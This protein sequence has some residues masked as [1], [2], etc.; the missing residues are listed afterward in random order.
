MAELVEL[1]QL[2]RAWP[3]AARKELLDFVAYLQHK[4]SAGEFQ[5]SAKLGGLWA[6]IPLDVTDEDVRALRQEVTRRLS[7]RV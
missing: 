2:V 1:E 6:G 5:K 3:P 7:G 4:Y